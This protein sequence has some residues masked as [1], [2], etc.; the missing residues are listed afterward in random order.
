MQNLADWALSIRVEDIAEAALGRSKLLL[1]DTIGCCFSA[2]AS[3]TGRAVLNAVTSIGGQPQCSIIGTGRKAPFPDAV[4]ANGVLLRTLDLND[5]VVEADGT[6]GGHPSDNIPVALAAGEL[7]QRSGRDVLAAIVIGYEVFGHF[8]RMMDRRSSWDGVSASGVVAPLVAGRLM[9]LD[10]RQLANAI[11]LSL[12]R[13]ATSAVV[14]AGDISAAKS[15]ANAM[16]AQQGVYCALLAQHGVTGPLSILEHPRGMKAI[17]PKLASAANG[18]TPEQ[19][20]SYV[21]RA[22][23]KTFPCVATA[24]GA[25]AAALEMHRARAGNVDRLRRVQI[26]M[27]DY[28]NFREHQQDRD[29]A[30]PLSREAADHSLAFLVAVSLIDGAFGPAQ[31]ENERWLDPKVLAVMDCLE[32]ATDAA[33]ARRAPLTYSCILEAQDHEGRSERIDVLTSFS[34]AGPDVDVVIRKFRQAARHMTPSVAELM[35]ERIMHL[36]QRG[37]RLDFLDPAAALSRN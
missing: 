14:R 25:V 8:R 1:L 32:F 36:D 5:Y 31:F 28:P 34:E 12:S 15:V 6:I 16:V 3:E 7:F 23:V 37:G 10:G 4:L 26:V 19:A 17:F 9:A 21:M 24:Q 13:A 35:I 30:R 11:A 20:D 22:Q 33:L 18:V 2:E 29:R 27:P